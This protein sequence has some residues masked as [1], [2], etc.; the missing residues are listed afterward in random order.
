MSEKFDPYHEWLGIPAS[1]QPPHH[2]RLLAITVFEESATVIEN[3]ADQRMAHLRTFQTG[4]HVGESQ[5]LLNEVAAAKICLLNPEKKAA[6][7]QWLRQ[8]LLPVKRVDFGPPERTGARAT[9]EQPRSVQT[10]SSEAYAALDPALAAV[11]EAKK[12]SAPK[13]T[14]GGA[15][16]KP[17]PKTAVFI[18][19]AVLTVAV[20][21]LAVL[22]WAMG[23]GGTPID[24][25][26]TKADSAP[27]AKVAKDVLP[28]SP[29]H[30]KNK[31]PLAASTPP[32]GESNAGVLKAA[33]VAKL[34]EPKVEEVEKTAL[35]P[36]RMAEAALAAK[37]FAAEKPEPHPE[38][39]KEQ[40]PAKKIDPPSADEQKRLTHEIDDIYRI[41][42]AKDQAAKTALARKLLEDGRKNEDKRAEQFVLLCR[43]E[44]IACDAGEAGLMEEAVEAT[45]AAGFN[46]QPIQ[47]ESRLWE[48]LVEHGS[49]VGTDQISAFSASCV[50]FAEEAVAGG[51]VDEAGNVLEAAGKVVAGQKRQAQIAQRAARTSTS[52][53]RNPA[54]KAAREKKAAQAQEELEEIDSALAALSD[55]LKGLQQARREYEAIRAAQARLKTA[56]DDPDACLAVGRW[57]CISQG[58]WDEGLKLLAKGS[59]G[60][61]KSLAA[62][63]LTS[64]PSKAEQ[65]VARG[66]AWWDLAEKADGKFR[67]A[68]RRRAGHWYQEALPDLAPGLEKA[69]V[70]KRLARA[71]EEPLPEAEGGPLGSR[72]PLA[73]A[74]FNERVAKQHQTRWARYLRVPVVQTNSIGMKLM[75]IP[76][77]EFDMGS[78]ME[79]IEE[80]SRAPG[81]DGWYRERLPIEGPRHRVRITKPYGLGA[82]EV[83]Q[84][85]YQRVMG[86]NPSE[87]QGDLK[88]PVEKVSWE[89]AVEFCWRLSEFPEEKGA[90]RRYRLPTEAQWEYA[91]RAGNPAPS[92]F[93]PQRGPFS[94]DW[95]E[96][97]L[98]ENAW[99]NANSGWQT[100]PVGQKRANAWGLYDMYGNVWQWCED[101]FGWDYYAKSPV[102]DPTGPPAGEER[103]GRGGSWFHPA[104][105]C[106][107]AFREHPRPGERYHD[108]G[109]RICLV[110]VV[111]AVDAV[112]A[113]PLEEIAKIDRSSGLGVTITSAQ[114]G[115]GDHW[116]DV[117]ERVKALLDAGG[118]IWATCRGMNA[119]P[120]PR[121]RKG[122]K[123][124]YSKD[125][126]KKDIYV[127]ENSKVDSPDFRP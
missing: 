73:V 23:R 87:F 17:E 127:D 3:A 12:R 118:D 77:G 19:A 38:P 14:S 9:T 18:G 122:L 30:S 92:S 89:D 65:R 99:F 84:E 47:V 56:P 50:K 26:L 105:R 88:R 10:G 76:P 16:K 6:Y 109:F 107:S 102:D 51:A 78:P 70:E 29:E 85:Q 110:S 60:G 48:R 100:H 86:A 74:P 97:S 4:K 98:A 69:K 114:W 44:E 35:A 20:V 66:D 62:E 5:Q 13:I 27:P 91:C 83:T 119:D 28:E 32:E 59:D 64:K 40:A 124:S 112:N 67:A 52:R 45:A 113:K 1:E 34:P 24:E 25:E 80:Q 90:K 39:P 49:L 95:G 101:R 55:C 41:G 61:L 57:Y 104:S 22:W 72:P 11:L 93:S 111:A 42:E 103:V 94:A 33:P 79:L 81:S 15:G 121:W 71:A 108:W 58:D 82:T 116:A 21:G 37:D 7:D 2:Y 125:G 75:L 96:R 106:R 43:A 63:E 68:M 126:Q 8:R 123:I 54:E 36:D 117:T 120:T 115:G 53:A 31:T 46:I